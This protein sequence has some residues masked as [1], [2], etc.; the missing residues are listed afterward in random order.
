[1]KTIV[2]Y[3]RDTGET[4][5]IREGS[6][7]EAI[8]YLT[9][10]VVLII[11]FAGLGASY[12]IMTYELRVKHIRKLDKQMAATIDAMYKE[13]RKKLDAELKNKQDQREASQ[14]HLQEL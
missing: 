2:N 1:M 7:Q 4:T 8:F 5:I 6:T 10:V 14:H 3:N 12:D 9:V 11:L 13:L